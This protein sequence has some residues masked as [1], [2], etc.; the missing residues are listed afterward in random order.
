MEQFLTQNENKVDAVLAENDGMAGGVVSALAGQGLAGKVPVS[1]QDGDLPALNRIAK[2]LQTVDVWK[3]ARVLGKT[4]GESALQLC[5]G[6]ALDQV[7]SAKPFTTPGGVNVS[8]I[9]LTPQPINVSNL[10]LVLDA[11]W[12]SQAVLCQGVPAGTVAVCG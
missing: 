11:G 1:G 5:V 2:G 3:D 7:T 4:A 8:G 10:N 12:I 9:L 6:T